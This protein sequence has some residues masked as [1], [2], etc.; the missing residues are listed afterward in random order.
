MRH[1]RWSL[2]VL[3]VLLAG[4]VDRG[5]SGAIP[6]LPLEPVETGVM[7]YGPFA[8]DLT[9]M[10]GLI[11]LGLSDVSNDSTFGDAYDH[12]FL[13]TINGQAFKDT[14]GV[15]GLHHDDPLNAELLTATGKVAGLNVT[16]TFAMAG[17]LMRVVYT[18]RNPS[19]KRARS[20]TSTIE[21]DFGSDAVTTVENTSDGDAALEARDSWF[22]VSN[23]GP[24]DD[25]GVTKLVPM[26]GIGDKVEHVFPRAPGPN[27]DDFVP[28]FRYRVR[29]R[30]QVNLVFFATHSNSVVEAESFATNLL[31]AGFPPS[32]RTDLPKGPIVNWN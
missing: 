26:I 8:N 30:K 14:D 28:Q 11:G 32:Y 19:R 25:D 20:V 7:N 16:A 17:S 10:G 15:V 22:V 23:D 3:F 27:S 18:I 2:L 6:V 9:P 13:F 29:P 4:A 1:A 31:G 5:A 21:V 24:V 12:A